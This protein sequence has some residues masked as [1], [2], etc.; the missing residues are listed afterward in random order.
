VGEETASP[1]KGGK[2]TRR[3]DIHRQ[4]KVYMMGNNNQYP[5]TYWVEWADKIITTFNLKRHGQEYKGPC[6][7]CGGA[8]RFWINN[9]D[10][11]VRIGCRGCDDFQGIVCIMQR[12]N[13]WPLPTETAKPQRDPDVPFG[14]LEVAPP[15]PS[16]KL[17]HE[18][19]GVPL[20]LAKV[21]GD[22]V[23]VPITNINREK[24]GT[25]SIAPDGAKRFTKDMIKEGAFSVI[26]G[27]LKGL[28]YIAEGWA[29]AASVS[30][31]TGRPTVFALDSG[32]MPKV[33]AIL[34]QHRPEARFIV[35]AD[36]DEAGIKAAEKCYQECGL[37][38]IIAPHA[39]NDWNDI[40]LARGA[41][42]VAKLLRPADPLDEI[43]MLA[44]AQPI[45]TSN[46]IVKG[47][48]GREQFSVVYGPSN[49]GKSFF[50]LD[51][52]YHIAANQA[53]HG[54]RVNGGAVLYLATEGGVAFKN[55]AYAVGKKY[56]VTDVPL[57][58]RPSP[59]NLLDPNADLPRL[60]KLI[61]SIQA[62]Y[63]PIALIV[64]DTLSRA[65]AGGNENGPEDMTAFIQNIDSLR[66]IAK[67]S[68]AVVHHSGKDTAQGARGHSSLRAATDT[69]IE[70]DVNGTLR[71][72]RATKQR[73]ME[74]GKEFVFK[75]DV[76]VLGLDE[77]GD[78]VTTCT[79]SIAD[80][81]EVQEASI[82]RPASRVQAKVLESYRQLRS[83]GIGGPNPTGTG[84]PESGTRWAIKVDDLRDLFN[85]KVDAK[86][87][88]SAWKRAID[89]M[90]S[91]GQ[92]KQ[93]DGHIWFLTKD[94]KVA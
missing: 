16:A 47:W 2:K 86:N 30:L 44:D 87:K 89:A 40:M 39:G 29:T 71:T 22:K 60:E 21:S 25:Q 69:E 34:S 45:L 85:G 28:C 54:H 42:Y 58:I 24:V 92:L 10:G 48:L 81:D 64:V 51:L 49:V 18:R 31:A 17:Y 46:Y 38:Y 72:A 9:I 79:I 4:G 67:T 61:A 90:E 7:S 65:M 56:G 14:A 52:C 80:D 59:V 35:A 93:N 26:N 75:L 91:N 74:V 3:M 73:D 78:D 57:A 70:L 8:D 6:P 84:W 37:S 82:K 33:A 88:S 36:N 50:M 32:N 68:V 43:V 62:K 94:G 77:D 19:K 76:Q 15:P 23:Y 20:G 53:W 27:P 83:D 13:C 63:G 12:Y 5:T 11:V 41:E 66:D 1:S 55:R